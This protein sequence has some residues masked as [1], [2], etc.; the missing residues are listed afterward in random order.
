MRFHQ[1]TQIAY[2]ST[3]FAHLHTNCTPIAHRGWSLAVAD[4]P[5]PRTVSNGMKALFFKDFFKGVFL[6]AHLKNIF[7]TDF[8][9]CTPFFKFSHIFSKKNMVF[10]FLV[11]R[12]KMNFQ[13]FDVTTTITNSSDMYTILSNKK[14]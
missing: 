2:F 12:V 6:T 9:H 14:A 4:Q 1:P 10:L 7:S 11:S 3:D 5:R 13:R 8:A